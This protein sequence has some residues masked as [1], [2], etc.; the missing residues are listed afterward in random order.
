[1]GVQLESLLLLELQLVVYYLHWKKLHLG[2]IILF[3]IA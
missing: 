3:L 2:K 1:M